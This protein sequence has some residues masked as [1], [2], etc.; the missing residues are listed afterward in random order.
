MR[1]D[2][3]L[4]HRRKRHGG[5]LRADPLDRCV[6][7][8]ERLRGSLFAVCAVDLVAIEEARWIRSQ[9]VVITLPLHD[10]HRDIVDEVQ[11]RYP[12]LSLIIHTPPSLNA[13]VDPIRLEQVLVNLLRNA[14]M[15]T[16]GDSSI[17]IKA[18]PEPMECVI[19]V[20]DNGPG[21][22]PDSIGKAFE[23]FYRVPGSKTGGIG[24]GLSIALGFVQA[25]KGKITVENNPNAG[26]TFIVRLPM[27]SNPR[28]IEEPVN[29]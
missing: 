25:H 28:R 23:K 14:A 12:A 22:P 4:H 18:L 1:D 10:E 24:L 9:A 5:E 8:V 7:P 13:I 19:T 29:D 11:L 26:A 20:T 6:E 16:P 2:V 21:F 17:V 15:H 3:V 27:E